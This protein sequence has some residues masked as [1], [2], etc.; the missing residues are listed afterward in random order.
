[1]THM[2]SQE[3]PATARQRHRT[4]DRVTQILEEVVYNPGATFAELTRT[5]DAP[6]SSVYGF[7]QGL[8]AA[9][10]LF[11]DNRRFYLGPAVY[12]LTLASGHI[13]AGSVTDQDLAVLHEAAGVAVF[14]GVTAGDHLIY[15]GEAGS[16]TLTGFAARTNIRR[17]LLETAGGKALLAAM[18]E[19]Q[20]NSY[21]RRR[22]KAEE[23]QVEQFLSE[24]ASIRATRIA[25][26]TVVGGA[27]SAVATTL[28]NKSG[29]AV[30]E[31]TLVGPTDD[32]IGR[33]DELSATLLAH[34][35]AL[36]PRIG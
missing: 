14:L 16:D 15:V 36:Q 31:V 3:M 13:Q 27:R 2:V 12:G 32:I 33:D 18:P 26:N 23:S 22:T 11:E 5:L 28:I 10:W 17:T 6:K 8:L 30:A 7:I 34:V 21:L 29:E 24:C 20:L 35:D 1:M 9:G 4:I 25:R 19:V